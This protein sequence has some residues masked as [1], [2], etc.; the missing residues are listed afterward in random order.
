MSRFTEAAWAWTG[1]TILGRAEIRLLSP[2]VYEVGRLGSGWRIEAPAGFTC[3]GPSVPAIAL[4][5]LPIGRMA[6]ASVIHD[7]MRRDR[8]WS[9]WWG[10]LVFFEAMGVEGVG[11]FWR[12]VAVAA[13]LIN[14][15][16]D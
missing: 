4:R 15:R 3:D 10:D 11:L 6:R 9:K 8:R 7:V 13:V 16:R 1:E 5:W 2:L 12:L 14:F